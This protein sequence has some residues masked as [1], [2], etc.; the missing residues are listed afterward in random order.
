MLY[1]NG[2]NVDERDKSMKLGERRE[3]LEELT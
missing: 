3:L 2:N 1:A